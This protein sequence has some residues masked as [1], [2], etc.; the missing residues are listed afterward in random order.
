MDERSRVRT[1]RSHVRGKH[2][3]RDWKNGPAMTDGKGTGAGLGAQSSVSRWPLSVPVHGTC[4][5]GRGPG[6]GAGTVI[7]ARIVLETVAEWDHVPVCAD[8]VESQVQ[9]QKRNESPRST[10]IGE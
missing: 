1:E 2:C 7:R 6:R 5:W 9:G 8:G 10:G 3:P 4:C